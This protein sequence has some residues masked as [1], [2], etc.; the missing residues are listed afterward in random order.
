MDYYQ[1]LGIEK[2]AEIKEI[3]K[4]YAKM[5]RKCSP[6]EHPEEYNKIREAYDILSNSDKKAEYDAY[7]NYND[8]IEQYLN[9]ANLYMDNDQY[10]EAIKNYKKILII[11]P[12]LAAIKN[13]LALAYGYNENYYECIKLLKE[14]TNDYQENYLYAYNLGHAYLKINNKEDA[15]KCWYTSLKLDSTHIEAAAYLVNLLIELNRNEEAEKFLLSNAKGIDSLDYYLELLK[16]YIRVED[17]EK[18]SLLVKDILSLSEVEE[19][20]DNLAFEICKFCYD[21]KGPFKIKLSIL[22][23]EQLLNLYPDYT[24]AY[25]L[26]KS[27]K[28]RIYLCDEYAVFC[29]NEFFEDYFVRYI[30]MNVCYMDFSEEEYKKSIEDILAGIKDEAYTHPDKN[31][32]MLK[33]LKK[34]YPNLYNLQN[35]YFDSLYK[36]SEAWSNRYESNNRLQADKKIPAAF[37]KLVNLWLTNNLSTEERNDKFNVISSEIKKLSRKKVKFSIISFKSNYTHLYELNSKY[38]DSVLELNMQQ[39]MS[40]SSIFRIVIAVIILMRIIAHIFKI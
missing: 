9:A 34:N 21:I 14:L 22:I 2:N 4:A 39:R 38:L 25:N 15:I 37:K 17:R 36:Y 11:E 28:S 30:Y 33:L 13:Q 18:I 3:K 24:D 31:L 10:S 26:L 8:E 5:L 19:E 35:E 6:E 29:R 32:D 12:K 40:Q 23:L 7:S 1:V 16:F 20:K 27:R